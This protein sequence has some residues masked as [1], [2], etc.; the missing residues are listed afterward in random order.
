M[1]Q[2]SSELGSMRQTLA[3]QDRIATERRK[4]D[5]E[6]NRAA[7]LGRKEAR[8]R[9]DGHGG[10]LARLEARWE[11]FF[12][13]GGAFRAV[14]KNAESLTTGQANQDKKINWILGLLITGLIGII[15]V[16]L[17]K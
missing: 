8:E 6:R 3:E 9:S 13:D 12:S 4:V 11:A 10:R 1:E 5:D 15:F 16:L 7:E 2:V 14:L 17:K